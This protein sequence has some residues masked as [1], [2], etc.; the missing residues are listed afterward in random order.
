MQ[1]T[2]TAKI[3]WRPANMGGR[4]TL[5]EGDCYGPIILREGDDIENPADKAYWS[6]LVKIIEVTDT[7]TIAKMKYL[8]PFAPD[9]LFVGTAFRLYEGK[10]EVATGVV[11][12][13]EQ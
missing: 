9:N 12:G 7:T 5:P 10:R 3:N 8:T 2:F 6:I 4:K 1:K 11:I 13:V